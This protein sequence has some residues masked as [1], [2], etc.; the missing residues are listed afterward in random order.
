MTQ[1]K[2]SQTSTPESVQVSPAPTS[3]E[4]KTTST[5]FPVLSRKELKELGLDRGSELIIRMK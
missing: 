5:L 2:K 1:S 3:K 4:T